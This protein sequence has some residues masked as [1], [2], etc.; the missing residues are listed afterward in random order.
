MLTSDPHSF[1]VTSRTRISEHGADQVDF[2]SAQEAP[3]RQ[4]LSRYGRIEGRYMGL[5]SPC[6]P[7]HIGDTFL[8]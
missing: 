1:S 7:E 5:I 8:P 3:S 2:A 4:E 6:R